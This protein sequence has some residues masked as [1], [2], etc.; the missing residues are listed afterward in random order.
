MCT[1]IALL[2]KFDFHYFAGEITNKYDR[3]WAQRT[4][5]KNVASLLKALIEEEAKKLGISRPTLID[6]IKKYNL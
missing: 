1:D 5:I 4:M 3:D 6:K 2:A